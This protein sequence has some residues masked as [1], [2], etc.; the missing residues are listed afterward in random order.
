MA[1]GGTHVQQH[2]ASTLAFGD[3]ALAMRSLTSTSCPSTYSMPVVIELRIDFSICFLTRPV[4][5]GLRVLYKKSC[6]ESRMENLRVSTFTMTLLTLNTEVLSLSDET[7][8]TVAYNHHHQSAPSRH[9]EE[10]KLT[11]RPSPPRTTS[12]N[13]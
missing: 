1:N 9:T 12:A 3:L 6:F 5:S 11:V 4:A 13:P 8:W 2:L 7:R 10:E